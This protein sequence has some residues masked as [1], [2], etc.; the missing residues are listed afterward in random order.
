MSE[1]EKLGGSCSTVSHSDVMW[2]ASRCTLT[3]AGPFQ[4]GADEL[5][6]NNFALRLDLSL[7]TNS[8]S[9]VFVT[10]LGARHR[11]K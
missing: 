1:T 5:Q 4:A 9:L 10:C 7:Q 8:S 6:M 11:N 2:S 3:T